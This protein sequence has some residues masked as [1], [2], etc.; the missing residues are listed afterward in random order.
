MEDLE[1]LTETML[2]FV[3]ASVLEREPKIPIESII[4]WDGLMDV[5]SKQGLLAWVWDGICKLPIQQQPPR[6]QRIN[7][8]LSSQ[9]ISN[10]YD[11]HYSILK[12]MVYICN[13]NNIRLLLLKGIG[14]SE[15]YPYPQL[16]PS[17]DIDV[18]FFDDFEK[19]NELFCQ[20]DF[21][22][23]GKHAEFTYEGV[24]VENH[25]T[26]IN[27]LTKQQIRAEKYIEDTL[28]EAQC[29]SGGYYILSPKGNIVYLLMHSLSHM[30][31]IYILPF[32]N[33]FDF[34]MYMDA[35]RKALS[36][37]VCIEI[38]QKLGLI[39]SFE[40][41]MYLVEW[42]VGI[43]FNEYHIGMIPKSDIEKAKEM[44]TF[45]DAKIRLPK[46]IPFIKREW[47]LLKRTY[48]IRWLFKYLPKDAKEHIKSEIR[49]E[50]SI[51]I[52]KVFHVSDRMRIKD[53]ICS[54]MKNE[55]SVFL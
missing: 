47:L 20:R 29:S 14:L 54:K 8:E 34:G 19:G 11:Y 33:I 25:L 41:F 15:L 23:G 17:G 2:E 35:H 24:H 12:K 5:S 32:R 4:D 43:P 46:S 9:E 26:F 7:W 53:F 13:Q 44:L 42:T 10:R 40:L 3:R 16:R 37:D 27:T 48:R 51:L 30:D 38:M 28:I 21:L 39:K 45:K 1:S 55:K 6:Q 36:P 50:V 18:Y 31:S 49:Q 52:R 22:F